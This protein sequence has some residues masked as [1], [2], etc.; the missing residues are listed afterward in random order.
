MRTGT[1]ATREAVSQAWSPVLAAAGV[2]GQELGRQILAL[3]HQV[4]VHSLSGPLT[5]PG[6]EPEEKVALARR[7]F[8]GTVDGRVVDLLSAMVR[9]RWSK[10]V[11]ISTALHDLGIEAIL[12]GAHADGAVSEIEQQLFE[13]HEQIA[14]DRELRE[15]LAPSRRTRTEARVRLAEAVFGPHISA[16][17]MSLLRWG[18][19]HRTEGGPLRNLRRVVELAAAMRHRIIADV[20][21]AIPMTTA[22]E[23][24]LRTILERR[25]GTRIDLNCEIDPEVIGG[26]RVMIRNHVLD[27]TVRG[28]VAEL[29]TRLAG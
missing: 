8:E 5:D 13:V 3:A 15:A 24:R 4:A 27:H 20:V 28:A 19:R 23:S 16:P 2:E 9:G 1:G 18:V 22:Q 11:D 29:R 17:A 25:L 21:T 14:G 10:P 6:R 12:A 26:A 7:V